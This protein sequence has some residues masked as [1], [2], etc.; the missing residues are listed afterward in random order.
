MFV[1]KKNRQQ[2]EIK[3]EIDLLGK[4]SKEAG[5]AVR[6]QSKCD[7][8]EGERAGLLKTAYSK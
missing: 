8:S 2:D 4:D 5:K 6:L 3:R 1:Q 7:L